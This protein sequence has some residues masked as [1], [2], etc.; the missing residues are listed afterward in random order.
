MA[1]YSYRV[2]ESAGKAWRWELVSPSGQ[3]VAHGVTEARAKAAAYAMLVWLNTVE[4]QGD[5]IQGDTRS[6]T[7]R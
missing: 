6:L 1:H 3:I 5:A 2:L 7:W 4:E